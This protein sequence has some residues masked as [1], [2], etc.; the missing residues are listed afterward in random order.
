MQSFRATPAS[1]RASLSGPLEEVW[2]RARVGTDTTT[3]LQQQ[4]KCKVLEQ[5][6]P[7]GERRSNA[8]CRAQCDLS[9]LEDKS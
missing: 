5:H 1:R 3:T 9:R 2:K 8:L 4:K 7:L 6:P